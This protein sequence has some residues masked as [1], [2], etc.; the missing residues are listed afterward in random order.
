MRNKEIHFYIVKK[1]DVYSFFF[2]YFLSLPSNK[3]DISWW[4]PILD[5]RQPGF[6]R[7]KERQIKWGKGYQY[8]FRWCSFPTIIT[9]NTIDYALYVTKLYS[10]ILQVSS[11][12][13]LLSFHTSNNTPYHSR[14]LDLYQ[15]SAYSS[16]IDIEMKEPSKLKLR[17][18]ISCTDST[19]NHEG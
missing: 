10:F 19:Q 2:Y 16:G 14:T 1:I 6:Y 15:Q 4:T 12:A 9:S 8:P 3:V 17:R 11:N 7:M 18:A 13:M 5:I